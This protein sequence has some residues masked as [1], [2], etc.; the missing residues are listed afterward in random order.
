MLVWDP[1]PHPGYNPQRST[2]RWNR[3]LSIMKVC[4]IEIIL[5]LISKLRVT[6]KEQ[7]DN[8]IIIQA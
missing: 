2:L 6:M 3:L 4:A 7:L 1:P 5:L 8:F